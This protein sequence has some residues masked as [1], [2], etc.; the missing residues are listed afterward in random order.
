MMRNQWLWGKCLLVALGLSFLFVPSNSLAKSDAL[1][2]VSVECNR[3]VTRGL[4]EIFGQVKNISTLT[5]EDLTVDVTYRNRQ[6]ALLTEHP[7]VLDSRILSP[8]EVTEVKALHPVP[9]KATHCEFVFA[10]GQAFLLQARQ[11]IQ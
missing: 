10:S 11:A 5:I 9:K 4:V 8:G 6:G 3:D 1:E 7:G 2:F